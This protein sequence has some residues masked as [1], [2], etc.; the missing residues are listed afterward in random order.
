[1]VF[2]AD[3]VSILLAAA[4]LV[5]S[6][7]ALVVSVAALWFTSLRRPQIEVDLA[8]DGMLAPG[9]MESGGMPAGA[10]VS[11]YLFVA[12]TGASG[13][14]L[15]R[16]DATDFIE[17]NTGNALWGGLRRTHGDATLSL[18]HAMERDDAVN[19]LFDPHLTW[20]NHPPIASAAEYARRLHTL[21]S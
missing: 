15:T 8:R 21:R 1:M 4:A 14:V 2:A 10:H 7:A 17:E 19:V 11:L 9:G 16:F 20:K 12:N 3:V 5:V 6:V 13:T 18:P